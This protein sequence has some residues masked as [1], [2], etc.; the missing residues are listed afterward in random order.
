MSIILLYWI[1]KKGGDPVLITT[2]P[3]TFT[4]HAEL[5][6]TSGKGKSTLTGISAGCAKDPKCPGYEDKG[7]GKKTRRC[8]GELKFGDGSDNAD[9]GMKGMVA[10]TGIK[11]FIKSA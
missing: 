6:C 9:T 2:D 10:K 5:Q 1:T 8:T 11:V 3:P 4:E 7:K